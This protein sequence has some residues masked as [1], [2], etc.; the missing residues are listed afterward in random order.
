MNNKKITAGEVTALNKVIVYLGGNKKEKISEAE[1]ELAKE[2]LKKFADNC[3][4]WNDELKKQFK[5]CV[6]LLQNPS[7]V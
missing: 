2:C 7:K 4:N 6:D 5:S 3:P 1:T